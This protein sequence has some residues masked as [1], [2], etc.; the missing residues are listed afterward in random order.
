MPEGPSIAIAAEELQP[1]AGRRVLSVE[2]NSKEPIERLKGQ[3]ERLIAAGYGNKEIGA[4]LTLSAK[5]VDAHKINA[6]R[7]L[8]LR[9]RIDI[10]K[11]AVLQGWL[12]QT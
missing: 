12:D 9:G 4:Q 3:E 8:E 7:K 2:G 11:Y 10:V 1:F 5:T 6:M